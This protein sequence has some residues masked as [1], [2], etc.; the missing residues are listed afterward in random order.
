MA[1]TFVS[2]STTITLN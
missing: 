2:N 1:Q